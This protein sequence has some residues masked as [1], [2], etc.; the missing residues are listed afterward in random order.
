MRS[1]IP[2]HTNKY[3]ARCYLMPEFTEKLNLEKPDSLEF[4]NVAVFN[5]NADKIEAGYKEV[6]ENSSVLDKII[7]VDPVNYGTEKPAVA[8]NGRLFF[9][10]D[11]E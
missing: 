2:I 7:Y 5:A 6:M 4:Y 10:L 1:S 8:D 9:L 3:E 11:T